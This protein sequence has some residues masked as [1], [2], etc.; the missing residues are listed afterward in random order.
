MEK[1]LSL[2]MM[3]RRLDSQYYELVLPPSKP[4][5]MQAQLLPTTPLHTLSINE[6][7]VVKQSKPETKKKHSASSPPDM[8]KQ[9]S[10]KQRSMTLPGSQ[11]KI[12]SSSLVET[13]TP[14]LNQKRAEQFSSHK[15]TAVSQ[16]ITG[17]YNVV[18]L[19]YNPL[20]II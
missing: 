8:T 1:L 13:S 19:Y 20:M 6:I 9:S 14:P 10:T 7:H 16:M 2:I 3:K 18:L 12:S 15:Q 17:V 4:K 11:K 5:S